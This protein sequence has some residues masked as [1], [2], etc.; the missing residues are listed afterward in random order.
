MAHAL[1]KA[2]LTPDAVRRVAHLSRLALDDASI[3]KYAR[4]LRAVLDHAAAL[5]ELD[6][7]QVAPMAHPTDAVNRWDEDTPR[8]GLPLSVLM[9]MAPSTAEP[10]INVP[11]VLVEGGGA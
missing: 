10:F 9:K 1:P 7:Q 2:D 5:R 6:L 3:K 11:K 4:Q 8:P